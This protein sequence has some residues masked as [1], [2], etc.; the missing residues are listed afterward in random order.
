M[1]AAL[2][3]AALTGA[4]VAGL[5]SPIVLEVARERG[6]SIEAAQWTLTITLLVGVVATP[7]VSRLGDG[8]RTR[9]V[10]VASLLV[11]AGGSLCA[12]A[13]PTFAGL[14]AG[15]ALQGLGYAMV[16]L[17]VAIARLHLQGARLVRTLAVL[18]TSV[19]VG[20]GLGNPVMGFAVLV[21]DYRAAFLLALVVAA[22]GAIWVW[23]VVPTAEPA[24]TPE[25]GSGAPVDV[26]GAVLL[27][28]GLGASLLA[29]AKGQSWGWASL[30]VLGLGTLGLVALT[31]CVCVELRVR[32]PL[33]DVRLA[34]AP[35]VLGV[36]LAAILLGMSVFGGV[37][38][39]ILLVE[40]PTVDGLGLGYSVFVNGLLMIPMSVATLLSP[41]VSRW[42]TRHTGLRFVLPVGSLA[43]AAA[44]AFFA[45][46]H[47]STWH[48][49]VA[50][51]LMG[52]GIGVAYAV[53]PALII[54]R[55]PSERTASATGINQVLR[56]MGG[57][58]GAAAAAAVLAGHVPP[59]RLDP[60]ESGY[61]LAALAAAG[62]AVVAAVVAYVMVPANRPDPPLTVPDPAPRFRITMRMDSR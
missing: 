56:L 46:A 51:T 38:V 8:H 52:F 59:G 55:T 41:P 5:G 13:V 20:V 24:T 30:P 12:A 36:N 61:V 18:S 26:G 31:A 44:F 4:V 6:V 35:G 34:A 40:R 17:T 43:V 33:V 53:M 60:D 7:V 28:V 49:V 10:L 54:E 58:V 23:R 45:V 25:T 16:P 3:F 14:L 57:A 15:R 22:A 9:P 27:G 32:S 37:A 29:V 62:A 47:H 42:V 19:A 2:A 11:V 39:I 48:I 1:V 21:A 50:M